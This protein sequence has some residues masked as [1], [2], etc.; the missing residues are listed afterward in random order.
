[1]ERTLNFSALVISSGKVCISPKA[2]F[3]SRPGPGLWKSPD[4]TF[5][6]FERFLIKA[7]INMKRAP[8]EVMSVLG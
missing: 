6:V 3:W 1:V 7:L 5:G 4:R 8:K 2:V